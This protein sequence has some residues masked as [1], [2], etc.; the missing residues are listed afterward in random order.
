MLEVNSISVQFLKNFMGL[1]FCGGLDK[2][3]E[4]FNKV[5]NLV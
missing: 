3:L 4:T 1:P 5:S 2:F